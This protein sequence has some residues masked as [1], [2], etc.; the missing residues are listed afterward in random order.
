MLKHAER[1]PY[2]L[3][4]YEYSIHAVFSHISCAFLTVGFKLDLYH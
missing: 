3:T 2:V 1:L 4:L